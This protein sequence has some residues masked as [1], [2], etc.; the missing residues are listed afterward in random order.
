[1][2]KMGG[3]LSKYLRRQRKAM[4]QPHILKLFSK[5]LPN[6]PYKG[7]REMTVYHKQPFLI[8]SLVRILIGILI[9]YIIFCIYVYLYQEDLLFIKQS[10]S[11]ERAAYIREAAGNVEEITIK[12]EDGTRLHGWILH[13]EPKEPLQPNVV[14]YSGGN[15]EEV[16]HMIDHVSRFSDWTFVFMNYRGYGLSA[17]TP[18]ETSLYADAL[19]VY[20][21]FE[22]KGVIQPAQTIVMGRSIGS[23]IAA[24]LA[25]H[26]QVRG[27]IFISP[28]DSMVNVAK[29]AY[30]FLPVNWLMKHRFEAVEQ[31]PRITVPLHA[32]IA[33]DD[34]I[35]RPERSHVLINH[36]GGDTHVTEVPNAGHNTLAQRDSYWRF[37][38]SSL[39]ALRQE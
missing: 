21:Y 9:G 18:S 12:A 36:W 17:G 28:Y 15:A 32:L 8:I 26:R 38:E 14:I 10:I 16:S 23:G 11:E 5:D 27:A 37:L 39:E 2:G 33:L 4:A 31:A 30:P 6:L 25:A 34:D 29:D 20:D 13:S 1:M 24:Y 19:L 22:E 3:G 7:C 35:I